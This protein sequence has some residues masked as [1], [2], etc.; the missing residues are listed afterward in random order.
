MIKDIYIR[1]FIQTNLSMKRSFLS[2]IFAISF[3]YTGFSQ[4][5]T[6]SEVERAD[7][8]NMNFEILGNFSGNFLVYKNLNKRQTL[9]IYDNSMAIKENI[10]L[11]FISDRTNNIDFITYPDRFL[12]VWQ[13][14]KGNTI[15]SKA[16]T[17][18]G[19][20]KLIGSVMDLDTSKQ[21]FFSS[22][23][24]YSFTWSE[25]KSKLLLY[26][27][28]T[29]N[30]EYTHVTKVYNDKFLL[31]DSSKMI[32]TYNDNRE[33]FGNLLIDNEGTILF[34]KIKQNARE[35]YINTLE[36]NFKKL[37]NSQLA[38][39]NIPLDKQLIQSP[40]IKVDNLNKNYLINTFSY[41]K[42]RGNVDGLLSAIISRD[43]FKVT[44][45]TINIF[46]DSLRAKLSGKTDFRTVYNNLNIRNVILKKDGGF[47]VL[48][49]EYI[50]QRRFGNGFNDRFNNGFNNGFGNNGFYNSYSDYY[51]YNRG[52]Y[53]YYRPFNDGSGRDIVY[54]YNDVIN[55]SFTKNLQ[56]QWNNVINKTTSDIEN[57]NFLSF[58]NM[59]AGR[60][61]H[62]LFLQKDNN[63]QIL[64]NY[65]VQPDG[66]II[67][68]PTLKG[69]EAGYNFMPRLAR[70][71]GVRQMLVPCIVRN[72]IA[73]AK[74]DF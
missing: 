24:Y 54:N 70:Q 1:N 9:T 38:T 67:R 58:T 34:E 16:A 71:T 31:L 30:N 25:D 72:N 21:S 39:V 26:K 68:Y 3:I 51:L 14:E 37:N 46:S 13:F 52:Y 69:R 11:D 45:Q 60:E 41:Q 6:Y 74:I 10:K 53:G 48:T 43:S 19:E 55:F 65:A 62:F 7:S 5:I 42:N 4:N 47:I 35:E 57:D 29:R 18:N 27:T 73:F 23:V 20:G 15:Y 32:F 56:L 64:S 49:E 50:R 66:S 40:L 28:Y 36:I 59:N 8:R 22:K 33:E 12:M 63:R 2:I 17:V 61:I 44:N